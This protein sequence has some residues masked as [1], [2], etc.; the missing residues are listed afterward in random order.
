VERN[1][2]KKG[3]LRLHTTLGDLNIELHCDIAPRTTQNFNTT[4]VLLLT[5]LLQ[6]YDVVCGV[7]GATAR[8][9]T[10]TIAV[11]QT[12]SERQLQLVERNP[13]KKG[14]LRLHT[15]LGDLNIE[16]HCDIAP[17]TTEN[18]IYLC[19][20]GYYKDTVF[21]RSI[22]NFMIQVGAKI[23][24]NLRIVSDVWRNLR[25]VSEVWCELSHC[26]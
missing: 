22:K 18:F 9:F 2:T 12:K 1:P 25:I 11:A 16:L 14:Y 10:S 15:T 6:L 24:V 4:H 19:E 8:A 5:S 13:T 20:M 26:V 7:T 3:Y 23:G 21:H 17:R